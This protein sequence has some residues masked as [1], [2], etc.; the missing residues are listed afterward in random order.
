MPRQKAFHFFSGMI[1]EVVAELADVLDR[2]WLPGDLTKTIF[3]NTGSE[4]TEVALRM[5]KMYT[6]GYEV[7]ALG[8]SWHGITNGASSVSMASDPQGVRRARTPASSLFPNPTPT[9][10]PIRGFLLTRTR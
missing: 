9:A 10:Q 3:I 7:L 1:P 8:G 2:D 5:A 4:A 6:D